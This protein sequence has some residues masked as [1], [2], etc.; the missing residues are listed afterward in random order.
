MKNLIKATVNASV[1][2]SSSPTNAKT[3]GMGEL[4]TMEEIK[5]RYP[6]EWVLIAYKELNPDQSDHNPGNC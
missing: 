5:R 1:L 2:D 6:Q 4:L 3:E